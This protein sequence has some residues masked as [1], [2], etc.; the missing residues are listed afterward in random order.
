MVA[1]KL[2]CHLPI[3][4]REGVR[5]LR[6]RRRS[7]HTRSSGPDG[8][9][10]SSPGGVALGVEGSEVGCEDGQCDW[11]VP[12]ALVLREGEEFGVEPAR[13]R[14]H[15]EAFKDLTHADHVVDAVARADAHAEIVEGDRA[16]VLRAGW[17]GRLGCSRRCGGTRCASAF[18]L[19][20][21]LPSFAFV[22][23]HC[24]VEVMRRGNWGV[25]EGGKRSCTID[26]WTV[27]DAV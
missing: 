10:S 6:D 17:D 26:G 15:V 3:P 1:P 23:A 5:T 7:S 21:A 27:Q 24:T 11:V 18:A 16:G 4:R 20:G 12:A 14:S 13:G 25:G 8:A 9:D 22:V 2:H 19:D